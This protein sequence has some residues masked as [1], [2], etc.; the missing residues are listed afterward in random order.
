LLAQD[1]E[2]SG[3]AYANLVYVLVLS[4]SFYLA[5]RLEL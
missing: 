3:A 2:L 4:I 5:R 1:L